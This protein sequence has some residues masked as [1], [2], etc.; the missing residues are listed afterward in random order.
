[1]FFRKFEGLLLIGLNAFLAVT[2]FV[3]GIGLLTGTIVPLPEMLQGSP[4]TSY[5]IP[6]LALLVLVSG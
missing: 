2:A 1:M 6:G 4:F 5:T 3:G